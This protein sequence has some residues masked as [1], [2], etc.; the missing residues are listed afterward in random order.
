[1][2]HPVF[3]GSVPNPFH[4]WEETLTF[5]LPT[6][7]FSA[8][9]DDPDAGRR[10]LTSF[11]PNPVRCDAV[12]VPCGAAWRHTVPYGAAAPRRAAPRRAAPRRVHAATHTL[13]RIRCECVAVQPRH[14]L[15]LR[16]SICL[17]VCLSNVGG[18]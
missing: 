1:M 18:L 15:M 17:P 11:T 16:P 4:P 10:S 9:Q 14:A 13:Q 2:C 7:L 5:Y 3:W 8:Y 6:P 12:S